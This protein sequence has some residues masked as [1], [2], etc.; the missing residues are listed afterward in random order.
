VGLLSIHA[1]AEA[2]DAGLLVRLHTPLP[3]MR[4]ALA[5][6]THRERRLGQ[7]LSAFLRHCR[8]KVGG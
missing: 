4:R 5:I 7:L 2:I 6:V 1:V 8:E 3:A